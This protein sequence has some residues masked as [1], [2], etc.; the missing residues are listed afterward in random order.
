ML[1]LCS[2]LHSRTFD[3]QHDYFHIRKTDLL[4]P[5]KGINGV[6]KGKIFASMLSNA[7]FFF[8]LICDM[9]HI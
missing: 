2:Q 4:T 7:S 9:I 8:N 3:M 1:T 5:P 6:C